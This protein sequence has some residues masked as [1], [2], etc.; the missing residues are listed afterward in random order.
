MKFKKLQ[1]IVILLSLFVVSC[2]VYAESKQN[3]KSQ[4][5]LKMIDEIVK[6]E[7]DR[8]N[9]PGVSIGIV[10]NDQLIYS[11]GYGV[12]DTNGTKVTPDTKFLIG[13][14]SKSFTAMA[15]MQLKDKGLLSL[16]DPIKK[17]LSWFKLKNNLGSDD[18]K[19]S[20]LLSHESG[21][22]TYDGESIFNGEV[23]NREKFFK[24]IKLSG[25]AGS[26][27][28]YSNLNFILLGDI[29][30]SV[31]G[32]NYDEYIK[33]NIFEPLVMDNSYANTDEALSNGLNHGFQPVFG[34]LMIL[35]Q[36]YDQYNI[37]A[38]YIA[39]TA[40]DMAKYLIANM[41]LDNSA[42]NRVI[43]R[44]SMDHLMVNDMGW[45]LDGAGVSHNGEVQGYHADI[46]MKFVDGLGFVGLVVLVNTNDFMIA[47]LDELYGLS[48]I[49]KRIYTSLMYRSKS[50]IDNKTKRNEIYI[51]INLLII[52]A[53]LLI[54]F[55]IYKLKNV[56][57]NIDKNPIKS[58]LVICL[59][60]F[61]AFSVYFGLQIYS[62]TPFITNLIFVPGV[63]HMLA[64]MIFLLLLTA[65]IQ[66]F[67][68]AKIKLQKVNR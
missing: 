33:Q 63:S 67:F 49:S 54:V 32:Q 19:I 59:N 13:S 40:N 20:H 24:G 14:C 16:D 57:N 45:F 30:E 58:V 5:D 64:V 37:P 44:E 46:S 68:F 39:S 2:A 48:S 9:I 47:E 62:G 60:I 15:I 3:L 31:S 56:V 51:V 29:V 6:E 4:Y 61:I 38:A 53:F 27:F 34:K 18:I 41:T 35:K 28:E 36:N 12:S 42:N 50:K 1:K 25:K 7:M 10:S 23:T 66:I 8:L 55:Q 65:F 52:T 11:K 26:T 17:Y 22:T 21:F 43:S